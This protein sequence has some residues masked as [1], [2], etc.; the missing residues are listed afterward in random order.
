MYL[1]NVGVEI[2]RNAPWVVKRPTVSCSLQ[3]TGVLVTL[4]AFHLEASD[5]PQIRFLDVVPTITTIYTFC[6]DLIKYDRIHTMDIPGQVSHKGLCKVF[7]TIRLYFT[8][9]LCATFFSI[10]RFLV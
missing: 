9:N 8:I 10:L 4:T 6:F 1:K 7:C 2:S 3:L 5:I